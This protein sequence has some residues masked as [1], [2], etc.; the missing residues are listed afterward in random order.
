MSTSPIKPTQNEIHYWF[1]KAGLISVIAMA[2]VIFVGQFGISRMIAPVLP[3]TAKMQAASEQAVRAQNISIHASN[4]AQAKRPGMLYTYRT[5]LVAELN[6]FV[7]VHRGLLYGDASRGLS[8]SASATVHELLFNPTDGL[9]RF[10]RD[11]EDR[12]KRDFLSD[13]LTVEDELADGLR[14]VIQLQLSPRIR[15]LTARLSQEARITVSRIYAAQIF[16]ITTAILLMLVLGRFIYR[17]LARRVAE[18]VSSGSQQQ[19]LRFD[20]VTGLAT[21]THLLSFMGDLCKFGQQHDFRSAVLDIEVS[22]IDAVRAALETSDVNEMMSM[23]ARRIESVCRSG[24]FI[25]RVGDNEFI[26][27][28]TSFEDDTALND[29]TNALRT[30]LS[31][32]FVLET[33]SFS[34]KTKIGIKVTDRKDRVPAA[35]LNQA[36]TAL[37]ISKASDNYD[38]QFFSGSLAPKANQREKEFQQIEKGLKSGEFLA[39]FH[40]IVDTLSG[41]TLGLEALVRWNHPRRGVLSP[42]HFMETVRNRN[43]SNDVSRAVLGDALKALREWQTDAIEVPYISINLDVDQ[44]EDRTFVDELKWIADSYDQSPTSI[45]LEFSEGAFHPSGDT[46]IL[47][48]IKRL[49]D[50]GFRI[51]LDDFGM[52]GLDLQTIKDVQ[53]EHVKIDRAFVTNLDSEAVQQNTTLELIKQAKQIGIPVVAEGVET[54]AERAVLQRMKADA[55]QGY[56][57]CEPV[58]AIDITDWLRT[59]SSQSS[60]Q[61]EAV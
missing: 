31:L 27:V 48:N 18:A 17:P 1:S 58:S 46:D 24:D 55:I 45:A 28:L 14:D 13:S 25:A 33:Q 20:D 52:L 47:D 7:A 34:L 21:R 37:K 5:Q 41:N 53:L 30:K 9:D 19:I 10:A 8:S 35:I 43:L 36:A 11:F 16:L 6:E 4:L 59:S 40:P 3:L 23:I 12:V 44:M 54:P 57:I 42:I 32:P 22:G 2:V 49:A 26:V 56:L 51:I 15:D 50:Y 39:H 61:R 60:D 29:V 38:I